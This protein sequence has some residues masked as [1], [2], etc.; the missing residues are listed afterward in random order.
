MARV[1][2]PELASLIDEYHE[3]RQ[4]M[5][6]V[7]WEITQLKDQLKPF[8]KRERVLIQQLDEAVG[9][10]KGLLLETDKAVL[11]V[12]KAGY[13]KSSRRYKAAFEFLLQKVNPALRQMAEAKLEELSSVS[14]VVGKFQTHGKNEG[15]KGAFGSAWSAVKKVFSKLVNTF[16]KGNE[17]IRAALTDFNQKM[18][19]RQA[20]EMAG[21][22]KV[23]EAFTDA[24]ILDKAER[25]EYGVVLW[26]RPKG[27][28]IQFGTH[29]YNPKNPDAWSMGHYFDV[30][31]KT[32]EEEAEAAARED[33]KKRASGL[34]ADSRQRRKAKTMK[35]RKQE[36]KGPEVRADKG[37]NTT[38]V[39]KKLGKGG[40]A[41]EDVKQ[42]LGNPDKP[43]APNFQ[44]NPD[45]A[46]SMPNEPRG[47]Y[48]AAVI[49]G[50][51]IE[52]V[53]APNKK[54][55]KDELIKSMNVSK[56]RRQFRRIWLDKG[57]KIVPAAG[58]YPVGY[59]PKKGKKESREFATV[60]VDCGSL[61]EATRAAQILGT[62]KMVK[63]AEVGEG[64]TVNVDV[65][66]SPDDALKLVLDILGDEGFDVE[67]EP[68]VVEPGFDE[69]DTEPDFS[70]ED[71]PDF[72]SRKQNIKGFIN[73]V[74]E[75][76]AFEVMD[77]ELYIKLVGLSED[78]DDIIDNY[79]K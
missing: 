23:V 62:R 52:R 71:M 43:K 51:E 15:I 55:A 73:K 10:T 8:A 59:E 65:Q 35:T 72:E 9:D 53:F 26:K 19:E 7:E 25:G 36:A 20:M 6:P 77:D 13:D 67:F 11:E 48:W 63:L 1:E 78:L 45:P 17:S 4:E 2:D 56:T 29:S 64:N 39:D 42:H 58:D 32:T 3:L 79:Y 54:A 41:P 30:Y 50:K 5:E 68:E 16:K 12:E 24:E 22:K 33:F 47:K 31:G 34:M 57:G 66:A 60:E 14:R 44:K 38:K 69:L 75:A 76:L 61:E 46:S 21:R 70:D 37:V 40:D 74:Q 49:D 18:G 27:D 28:G